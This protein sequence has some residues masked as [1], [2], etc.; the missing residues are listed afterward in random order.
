MRQ[1]ESSDEEE[2]AGCSQEASVSDSDTE[3]S[4]CIKVFEIQILNF[5]KK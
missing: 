1:L 2:Q 4:F 3:P 5:I